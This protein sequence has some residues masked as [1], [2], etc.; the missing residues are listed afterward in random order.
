VERHLEW[1][2]RQGI[3]R[4]VVCSSGDMPL[5]E[6]GVK[7][8]VPAGMQVDFMSDRM[9]RGAAGCLKDAARS[10]AQGPII[11]MEGGV[12]WVADVSALVRQHR[13][14]GAELTVFTAGDGKEDGDAPRPAGIYVFEK[15][16]LDIVPD[17]G[18]QD[19]KEQLIPALLSRKGRVA[20]APLGEAVFAGRSL[21]GYLAL[22]D[23][24]LAKPE[25]FGIDLAN[26]QRRQGDVWCGEGTR[27]AAS[28]R[29]AGPAVIMEGASVGEEAVIVGPSVIGRGAVIE[30]GAVVDES[31]VWDG[32]W[33]G[34]RARVTESVVDECGRVAADKQVTRKA[35]AKGAKKTMETRAAGAGGTD[36]AARGARSE[37]PAALT[38]G[39]GVRDKMQT[40][41]RLWAYAA[42]GAAALWWAYSEVLGE[43]WNVWRTNDNYSSG[44]L[45]PLLA[46]YVAYSQRK[47][48]A[49][50]A[51][52][53]ALVLGTLV[54]AAGFA[55]RFAGTIL[56]LGSA[57]RFSI[58][59]VV[60]G[61]VM[62]VFGIEV[63]RKLKWVLLFL[64]LMLPWPNRIYQAVS[65]PLQSW[66]TTS[67]VF[68][69][70]LFGWV[71]IREGNVLN[72]GGTTVAV[73]EACSGLRMLTAFMVVSGLIALV[74]KRPWWEKAIIVASS[75]PIAVAC[76]TIRLT[77]TAMAFSANYGEEVNKWFHDFGGIAMMPLA[78]G[79]L[80]GEI[81]IMNRLMPM[82]GEDADGGAGGNVTKRGNNANVQRA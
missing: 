58:I 80:A 53:P 13:Q 41:G 21:G 10:A 4:A 72:L 11:A 46:A 45:V 55:M 35:V 8:A 44:V 38:G 23:E 43:L 18:Y 79:L 37:T 7:I 74:V 47:S 3:R 34:T 49:E 28:A 36:A 75:V 77:V 60:T 14:G 76:N 22:V 26:Y 73:A 66:A 68:M 16:A 29:L 17:K 6:Y 78:L 59:V 81:W 42:L 12:A 15:E 64:V 1:L 24:A 40:P 62:T 54:I 61:L 2:S 57:E 51:V 50:A 19:I 71:V 56:F 27:V 31:V 67:A 39:E 70:E 63:T 33:I 9:P 52:R 69:L 25:R 20:A 32:G 30:A 5:S 65:L 82:V 48:L